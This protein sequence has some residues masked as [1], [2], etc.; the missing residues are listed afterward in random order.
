[1]PVRQRGRPVAV[2]PEGTSSPRV[3]QELWSFGVLLPCS[4]S[5]SGAKA[6]GRRGRSVVE[7][8]MRLRHRLIERQRAALRER[9]LECLWGA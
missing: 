7:H 6:G 4:S 3:W 5:V 9:N 1:M 8:L 2:P